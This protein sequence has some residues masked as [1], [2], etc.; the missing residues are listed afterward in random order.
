M[1]DV[2]TITFHQTTDTGITAELD[3]M[4]DVPGKFY[5]LTMPGNT[6]DLII[7]R[8]SITCLRIQMQADITYCSVRVH[9]FEYAEWFQIQ[10]DEAA[11]FIRW[12]NM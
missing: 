1:A 9:M 11:D 7:N 10:T 2:D 3:H 4:R 5:T 12:L 6:G 8:D